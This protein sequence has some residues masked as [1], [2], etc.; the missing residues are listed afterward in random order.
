MK[1]RNQSFLPKMIL[2]NLDYYIVTAAKRREKLLEQNDGPIISV[3]MSWW[4]CLCLFHYQSWAINAIWR[5]SIL[6]SVETDSELLKVWRWNHDVLFPCVMNWRSFL[7]VWSYVLDFTESMQKLIQQ[8]ILD[9]QHQI[10]SPDLVCFI[11]SNIW[12]LW[13]PTSIHECKGKLTFPNAVVFAW[14]LY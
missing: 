13:L 9:I 12:M 7:G 8:R 1:A 5:S 6:F 4:L 11:Q 10:F 14:I 2:Q 3:V